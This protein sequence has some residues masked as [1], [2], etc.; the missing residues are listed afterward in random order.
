[1]NLDEILAQV[2]NARPGYALA[3][4]KE[5][6]LPVFLL[7]ARVLILE[8]KQLNP[9]EEGCLRALDVGLSTPEDLSAFLGLHFSMLTP[10][11]AA[12]NAGEFINY[13]R[14]RGAATASVSIT[15]KGRLAITEA[16]L[17][18]PQELSVKLLFDPI[19]KRIVHMPLGALYKPRE[20]KDEGWA[21]VPLCGAKRPEVDDVPVQD[22]DKAMARLRSPN[23]T[24]AEL[25]SV[26]RI[27]RRELHFLPCLLLFYKSTTSADVHVAFYR[28]EGFSG[29]HERAF[30]DI[31]GPEQVGANHVLAPPE[32]PSFPG[33]NEAVDDVALSDPSTA[34]HDR[35][36]RDLKDPPRST[37]DIK[38]NGE[39]RD[40][41]ALT[42]QP[43]APRP[44]NPTL[45]TIRCHEHPPLLK[46]ALLSS[47]ER[48]LIVSP[49]IRD[50][51]VNWDFLSSID[52]LLRNGVDV[53]IGYGFVE[54]GGKGRAN[55]AQKKPPISPNAERDLLALA[56]RYSNFTF[57]FVGNTH[58]KLLV[59]DNEFA[60][61]TSF[62][63]LSFKGDPRE[64]PRDESGTLIMKAEYVEKCF[65]DG[66]D[67]LKNGYDH[68]N[69]AIAKPGS[70]D[71]TTPAM[72]RV[73]SKASR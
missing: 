15:S 63:W 32:Q 26:R 70:K 6:A 43:A 47:R 45:R 5:A 19:I 40:A 11:M 62:N 24:A 69:P 16:K 42:P 48:L 22:I 44:S 10:V 34:G 31:G 71:S 65:Q 13:S 72:Q 49:W 68:S 50:Q 59:S 27:D 66:V 18:V 60:V 55:P 35:H 56:K 73:G 53:F 37:P 46:K 52:A 61:T 64:K 3:S 23:D 57:K 38:S 21:E 51:V 12:L 1:M 17:V 28:D 30:R 8:K 9:I 7:T 2:A 41:A 58:R 54:E 29:E 39:G 67:L 14:V 36:V 4:F 20:V 25:L 33:G